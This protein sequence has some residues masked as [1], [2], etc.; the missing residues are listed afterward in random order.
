MSELFHVR[1]ELS[2]EP[3]DVLA[4]L[5]VLPPVTDH[6]LAEIADHRVVL[7]ALHELLGDAA[8]GVE[9]GHGVERALL[10]LVGAHAPRLVH[11]VVP[12]VKLPVLADHV[13]AAA[14]VE[15]LPV[16][17]ARNRRE[18]HELDRVDV[19]LERELGGGVDRLD[20]V[21][22]G[23]DH[24]HAV[25]PDLVGVEPLDRALDL[26]HVL[27]LLEELERPGIDRLEADVDV[28]AVCRLHELEELGI[29]DGFCPDL[30]APIGNEVALDHPAQ[31]LFAALLVRGEDV[32]REEGVRVAAVA[33]ELLQHALDRVGAEGVAVHA[34]HRAEGAGERATAR[35]RDRDDPAGLPARDE[36]V[37]R[38]RVHVEVRDLRT[39]REI[40]HLSAH[41]VRE[42]LDLLEPVAG[43]DGVDQLLERELT[44]AAH[45]EVRVLEPFLG[46][47]AHVRAAEHGDPAGG[48]DLVGEPVGLRRRRGDGRDGDQVGR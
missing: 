18:D 39:L 44:L 21:L 28:E 32:V 45:H 15:L 26:R 1:V 23:A 16:G 27:L 34:R 5:V 40:D 33:L 47:E 42:V 8:P 24:E 7:V 11:D 14:V 30:G 41:D 43:L 9:L 46:Q 4:I 12:V 38:D 19:V 25:D 31:E 20:V 3:L 6:S 37:V 13:L 35:R 48:A 17:R 10:Q 36:L 2:L 29:V 22:V